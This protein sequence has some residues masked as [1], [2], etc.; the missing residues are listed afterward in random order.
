MDLSTHNW[1]IAFNMPLRALEGFIN[2]LF[3]L[4]GMP[5]KSPDYNCISKRAKTAG[6]N[7]RAPSKGPVTHLVIDAQVGEMLAGL[8][9]LNKVIG[10]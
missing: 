1:D 3:K 2:S 10:L 4:M 6:I 8:K 5:L 9:V 7:Y